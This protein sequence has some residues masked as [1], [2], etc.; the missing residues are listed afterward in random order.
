MPLVAMAR[1]MRWARHPMLVVVALLVFGAEGQFRS[2]PARA[3]Q[4]AAK[5]PVCPPGYIDHTAANAWIWR[6]GET[7]HG[8]GTY[9]AW[10]D[11]HCQCACVDPKECIGNRKAG[12]EC[13]IAYEKKFDE[14][15]V[16]P[17]SASQPKVT[18][19]PGPAYVAPAP[20]PSGSSIGASG[21]TGITG[22]APGV[23]A[24]AQTNVPTGRPVGYM[25]L[26]SDGSGGAAGGLSGATK[27]SD[28]N[29]T[30]LIVLICTF[31]VCCVGGACGCFLFVFVCNNEHIVAVQKLRRTFSRTGTAS[32]EDANLKQPR[33]MSDD[34]SV[35]HPKNHRGQ[36][37]SSPR[38]N[39]EIRASLNVQIGDRP[40]MSPRG[41]PRGSPRDGKPRSSPRGHVGNQEAHLHDAVRSLNTPGQKMAH[42]ASNHSPRP[43][44]RAS[45]NLT[46]P[47]ASPQ[48]TSPRPSP[49]AR[50][51]DPR[52]ADAPRYHASPRGAPSNNAV[53]QA[54]PRGPRNAGVA[55]PPSNVPAL[56]LKSPRNSPQGGVGG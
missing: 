9:G 19:A 45:L 33:A 34:N 42:Q 29:Y 17:G 48:S 41:S 21:K 2:G 39:G 27:S 44:P 40:A 53:I 22:V 25:A 12:D 8:A 46:P 13:V 52:G 20:S 4:R 3:L 7:C 47:N 18:P 32:L 14:T 55:G 51:E 43:S 28:S 10:S 5:K 24:T 49:R 36:P 31:V 50:L 37:P 30:V 26:G 54:S 35:Q 16:L 56:N 38:G 15:G 11:K 6:C 1:V 23:Q